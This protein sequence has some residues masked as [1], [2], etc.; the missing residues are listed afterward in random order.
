MI[1]TC[2]TYLHLSHR[3]TKEIDTV[4]VPRTYQEAGRFVSER[5]SAITDNP[6]ALTNS[7]DAFVFS[8]PLNFAFRPLIYAN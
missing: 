3:P 1:K 2:F 5:F 8:D 7:H 6:V 4:T